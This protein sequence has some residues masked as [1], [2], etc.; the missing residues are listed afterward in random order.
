MTRYYPSQQE[1]HTPDKLERVLRDAYDRIYSIAAS[2]GKTTKALD[3]LTVTTQALSPILV[4]ATMNAAGAIPVNP[5]GTNPP[6]FDPLDFASSGAHPPAPTYR[7]GTRIDMALALPTVDFSIFYQTD[8]TLYYMAYG[9]AWHYFNGTQLDLLANIP[10][11]FNLL[12]TGAL[13]YATDYA[14]LYRWSGIAWAFAPT[15]PGSGFVVIGQPTGVAPNGGVW[16]VCDG[17]LALIAQANGTIAGVVTQNLQG[18]VFIKGAAAVAA[19][20]AATAS[21][22][23]VAKHATDAAS[24]GTPAGTV[25]QPTFTGSALGT[26]AH[27][28]PIQIPSNSVTE[29]LPAATFG[30]GTSRAAASKV[31]TTADTTSASVALSQ[32]ISAGTPAGTVSQPSFTGS[33]LTTHTHNLSDANAAMKVPSEANGGLPLRISVVYYIR[34]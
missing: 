15:D 5:G 28:L 2:Q 3:N 10:A 22:W 24:A 27:E 26:H 11:T 1:L 14:H 31:T 7:A 12:D 21:T 29:F 20:Q 16:A 6:E 18:E 17:N 33:A 9:K 23:D 30:T 34:R 32:A 13:F 4:R 25:S 19:Q 8:T